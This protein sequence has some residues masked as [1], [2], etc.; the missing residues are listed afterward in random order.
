MKEGGCET[1]VINEGGW[2]DAIFYIKNTSE[3]NYVRVVPEKNYIRKGGS[4]EK[5][6]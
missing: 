3:N 4:P 1:K 5:N 6:K 2:S